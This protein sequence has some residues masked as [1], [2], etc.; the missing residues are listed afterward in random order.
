[1]RGTLAKTAGQLNRAPFHVHGSAR[2]TRGRECAPKPIRATR[3]GRL[4]WCAAWLS[5][6]ELFE[7]PL[8]LAVA[9]DLSHIEHFD[10]L[11]LALFGFCGGAAALLEAHFSVLDLSDRHLLRTFGD[12]A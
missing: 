8:A 9:E 7:I 10:R 6:G 5:R 2:L 12:G 4:R 11:W 3:C 1:M